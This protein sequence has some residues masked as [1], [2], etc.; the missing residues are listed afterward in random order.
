M[1]WTQTEIQ[2]MRLELGRVAQERDSYKQKC[3]AIHRLNQQQQH[4]HPHQA[5][6]QQQQPK[7]GSNRTSGTQINDGPSNYY[8]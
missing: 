2:R 5:P 4:S 8:L 3:D 7:S 6:Q 1:W